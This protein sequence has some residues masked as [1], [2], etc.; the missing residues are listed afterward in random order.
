MRHWT[1]RYEAKH[2]YLKSLSNSIGNFINITHT[3]ATRHQSYQCYYLS[4]SDTYE[5][6]IEVGP[7]KYTLKPKETVLVHVCM[8]VTCVGKTVEISTTDYAAEFALFNTQFPISDF[9]YQ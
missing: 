8:Y 3:L 7:G 6:K 9:L 5:P 4:G 1:I 2:Q